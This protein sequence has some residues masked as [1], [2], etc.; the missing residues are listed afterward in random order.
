MRQAHEQQMTELRELIAGMAVNVNHRPEVNGA[1]V[2]GV[3]RGQPI[4]QV[5]IVR[6]GGF[7]QGR[8]VNQG[9]IESHSK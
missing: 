3:T 5:R 8:N 9:Q 2:D 4:N 1:C 6:A 7:T